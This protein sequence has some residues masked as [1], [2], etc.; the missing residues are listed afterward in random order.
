LL[1]DGPVTKDAYTRYPALPYFK[2]IL[3][4]DSLIVLD[5]V[6]RSEEMELLSKWEN[7]F[8]IQIDIERS[9]RHGLAYIRIIS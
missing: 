4:K 2:S 3:S 9:T 6:N 5:D 1:V 8:N 7:D